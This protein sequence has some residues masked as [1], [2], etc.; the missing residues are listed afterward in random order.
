MPRNAILGLLAAGSLALM[1]CG[2]EET[3]KYRVTVIPKG[4]THEF[5]QSIHRGAERAAADL[6]Q[7]Q[8][9]AVKII[10][11]GPKREDDAEAQISIVKSAIGRGVSGIVLAPQNSKTMV[12]PVE[13]AVQNKIPVVIIDS[14]LDAPQLYV[15]YVATNNENGGRLAAQRLLEVLA[16]QGNKAPRL[17]LFRYKV[18]SESTEK[19]EKGFEDVINETI[20]RQKA[21]NEPAITWV[22][23]P[24]EALELG[25]TKD[26]ALTAAKPYL[27][28][29]RDQIDGIFAPNESSASGV[30]EALRSLGLTKKI[31]LVG[32]DSSVP[33]LQALRDGEVDGLVLQDPYRMG[34]L[35]VW[36]LVQHLEGQ[37]VCPDG[38]KEL[39]TGETVITRATLDA[40]STRGLFEADLQAKRTIATPALG[41]LP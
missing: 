36:T 6:K 12:N 34:Y 32:F 22:T 15:K 8:G 3:A 17:V 27:S 7:K 31:R 38:T 16:E 2:G 25:S 26:S 11:D 40:V 18:G 14:G 33:L 23:P 24:A 1:G 21:A 39:S 35:A 4:L 30:V 28:P 9:L 19:R 5:W 41:K 29:R 20:A 13:Q 10:W 37:N